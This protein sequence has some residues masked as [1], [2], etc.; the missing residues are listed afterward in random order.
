MK[1][2]RILIILCVLISQSAF[3]QIIDTDIFLFKAIPGSKRMF[4]KPE[5]ITNRSGYN[6][7][8][9]FSPDSK[10][11]LFSSILDE[12]QSEI[13]SYT[14]A[15]KVKK[16]LTFTNESEFSPTFIQGGQ[17]ISAV[18]VDRDSS[19]HLYKYDVQNLAE[20][21]LIS[22]S[23]SIGYSCWINE[24]I[25]YMF[26]VG[27]LNTLQSL[28]VE[29]GEKKLIWNEPG[30]CIKVN[31]KSKLVYF[32]SKSDSVKWILTK[33]NPE[34]LKPMELLNMPKGVEDFA[35]F[36]DGTLV[37]FAEG[38][39]MKLDSTEKKWIAMGEKVLPANRD[40]FRI[41]ISPND[42]YI[43]IVTKK[44]YPNGKEDPIYPPAPAT[45]EVNQEDKPSEK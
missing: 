21:K 25:V 33:I 30:R 43:A 19:Q 37:T 42:N 34:N 29:T 31:P 35:F 3:A 23:D 20:P 32:V 7:Q 5:N 39:L 40:S 6:N 18:R 14:I 1:T 38:Q 13:W 41:T 8:P 11:I 28:N 16:Q 36:S 12:K 22:K 4:S 26:L 17:A 15:T 44:V 9:S 10:Q 27:E 2:K 24:K 45:K